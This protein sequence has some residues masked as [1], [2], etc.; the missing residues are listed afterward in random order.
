MDREDYELLC[1]LAEAAFEGA[2]CED[3]QRCLDKLLAG[4]PNACDVWLSYS[5]LHLELSIQS[6]ADAVLEESIEAMQ[7]SLSNPIYGDTV[8]CDA[9]FGDDT[10]SLEVETVQPTFDVPSKSKSRQRTWWLAGIAASILLA[11]PML[12][13][14]PKRTFDND[15]EAPSQIASSDDEAIIDAAR[16]P[17]PVA[18]VLQVDAKH[19][20]VEHLGGVLPELVLFQG[21]RLDLLSG[22]ARINMTSGAVMVATSPVS[23]IAKDSGHID[24]LRGVLTAK[25]PKWATGFV[26]ETPAMKV[27]DL[28]TTFT[29]SAE[30]ESS[31]EARVLEGLITV[32]PQR[33]G[34]EKA[35]GGLVVREGEA[36][37]VEGGRAERRHD[38]ATREQDANNIAKLNQDRPYKPIVIPG[39]G[40]GLQIGDEDP[41][42]RL[43]SVPEGSPYVVPRQAVV[44]A[45]DP[46]Y[47]SNEPDRSQWISLAADCPRVAANDVYT[48]ETSFDLSGFD[49]STVRIQC[50]VLADNG[51]RAVR[52]NGNPIE[53]DPWVDNAR[54]QKFEK[55]EFRA[56]AISNGFVPGNN[57]VEF[58]VWNGGER[59][60]S[61][62][63]AVPNPTAIRVEWHA[64]GEIL[65]TP[66]A[67]TALN[68]DHAHLASLSIN[69]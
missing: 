19:G 66:D 56:I 39:S 36:V 20:A 22:E 18:T 47:A 46:R 42:W 26:V 23:L 8:S 41:Y 62:V 40:Q 12:L 31:A 35:G 52:L 30:S 5:W 53:L 13:E 44:T 25:L 2:L 1:K 11:L 49:C 4:S 59:G 28:G 69:K 54:M 68:K 45:E 43:V 63:L 33:T 32:R 24:L 65:L 16:Q 50:Q 17:S 9:A 29:V 38:L 6:R 55:S 34:Q 48:F 58:D 10:P 61:R 64:F 14:I 67:V 27:T 51:V 21:D 7:A 3:D 60:H 15:V 57:V 37:R